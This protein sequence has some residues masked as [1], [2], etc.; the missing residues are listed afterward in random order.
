MRDVAQETLDRFAEVAD[1]R[2]GGSLTGTITLTSGLGHL[3]GAQALAVTRNG[4]V[5]L[6]IDVDPDRI[7]LVF[8][9]LIDNAIRYNRPGGSVLVRVEGARG[10]AS[11][12][13]E[14]DGPGI[15]PEDRSRVF[16]RFTRLRRDTQ[17][18]GSGLGLPIALSLAKAIGATLELTTPP[19]GKGLRVV[20]GFAAA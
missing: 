16:D 19:S 8:S 11:V 1:L 3:G 13:V 2:F 20:V 7:H 14:D 4:G 6:C 18:P 10:S 15:A 9:N 17:A 12:V 5:A